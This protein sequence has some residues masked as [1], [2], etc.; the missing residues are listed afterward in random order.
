MGNIFTNLKSR[1][2]QGNLLFRLIFINVAVFVAAT[3]LN[4]IAVLFRLD[5]AAI[6]RYFELPSDF[7]T[8]ITRPWTLITYMFFHTD[9][10]HILFNMLWLYWFGNM[11]LRRF[12]EKQL[13]GI[14]FMGGIFGGLL[15]M[16]SYNVFPVFDTVVYNSF[17][18]GASASVLA[19]VVATAMSDPNREVM[20]MFLGA[21]KLKYIAIFVV[22]L[23]F[24]NVISDNA[25]GNIAHLGGAL[26]GFIF[27]YFLRKGKDMTKWINKII[28]MFVNVLKPRPKMKVSK[29]GA[30][31]RQMDMDYNA[32]KK[33]NMQEIDAILDKLKRTGYEGLTSEEKSKLFNAGKK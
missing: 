22:A 23:S 16:I 27:V 2:F 8:F 14:Y 33:Q 29:G 32:R 31:G 3:I 17:L 15:Y 13:G 11:F 26:F 24:F 5:S 30:G 25:G 18:L 12:T 19:I 10:L 28:D 20:L 6:F 9:V 4:I 1:Y 21:I 7:H